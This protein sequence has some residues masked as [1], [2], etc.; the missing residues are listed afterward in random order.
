MAFDGPVREATQ[1]YLAI[2]ED[3]GGQ[4]VWSNQSEAPGDDVVAYPLF[5]CGTDQERSRAKSPYAIR[6]VLRSSLS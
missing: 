5:E 3:E 4:R 1:R 2:G 6:C